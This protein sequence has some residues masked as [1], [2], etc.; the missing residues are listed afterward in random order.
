MRQA[1]PATNSRL[2]GVAPIQRYLIGVG[3]HR[4]ARR[5]AIAQS[6]V[7]TPSPVPARLPVS[8]TRFGNDYST[9]TDFCREGED[10][11]NE[12]KT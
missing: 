1:E 8:S 2:A 12:N 4:P 3:G 6:I 11:G 9:G 10:A 5:L 7:V